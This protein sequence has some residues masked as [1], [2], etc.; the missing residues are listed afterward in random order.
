[1]SRDDPELELRFKLGLIFADP[2]RSDPIRSDLIEGE[3]KI[4]LSREKKCFL[5]RFIFHFLPTNAAAAP[6]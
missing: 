4:E 6:V 3:F 5:S 1:M 2:I